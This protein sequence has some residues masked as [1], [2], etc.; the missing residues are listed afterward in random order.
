MGKLNLSPGLLVLSGAIFCSLAETSGAWAQSSPVAPSSTNDASAPPAPTPV[1]N[2]PA[3]AATRANGSAPARPGV[4]RGTVLQLLTR[5]NPMLWPLAA[6]SIFTV[7]IAL[8]R[9]LALR[10]RRG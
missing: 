6:C 10:R 7:G 3:A 9:L 1:E 4:N 8:E 2:G 5:A